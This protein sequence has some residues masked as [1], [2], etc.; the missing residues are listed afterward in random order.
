MFK[1]FLLVFFRIERLSS[2]YSPVRLLLMCLLRSDNI[3]IPIN[4]PTSA[5]VGIQKGFP[6]IKYFLNFVVSYRILTFDKSM[7]SH[8]SFSFIDG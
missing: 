5:V 4:S 6:F 2:L 7:V 8:S 1:P 3:K